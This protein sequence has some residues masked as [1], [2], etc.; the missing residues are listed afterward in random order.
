MKNPVRVVIVDDHAVVRAGLRAMLAPPEFEIVGEASDG[1]AAVE[2]A[3][4][5][6]PDVMVMDFE[7]PVLD[8]LTATRVICSARPK[9]RIVLLTTYEEPRALLR[10]RAAGAV[11]CVP[12]GTSATMFRDQVS[13]AAGRLR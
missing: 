8:A 3:L 11:A 12:K 5:L 2:A 7:L 13:T 6:E 10:A 4:H 1:A 9:T